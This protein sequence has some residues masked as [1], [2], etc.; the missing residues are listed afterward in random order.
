MRF[1]A[2]ACLSMV[3]LGP[4]AASL[5]GQLSPRARS[6]EPLV[7]ETST[8]AD[9]LFFAMDPR[10]AYTRLAARIEVAP[11]DYE[12]RWRASR[13]ALVLGV[14]ADDRGVKGD[15]L[16]IAEHQAS[17]A[18]RVR[19]G[20]VEAMAWL[21][22]AKGR[23]ATDIVG[24][25]DQVRLGQEVWELTKRVLA[26]DPAHP[27]GNDVLGK[28]HQE[29]SKLSGFERFV[30][31]TFMGGGDPLRHSSWENSELY[32]QR[33]IQA[34]P[35]VVLFF[36][37]LGDTYRMQGKSQQ[38]RRAYERGL[39]VPDLYPPDP[40]FKDQIRRGLAELRGS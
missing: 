34:D 17:E 11:D 38:A 26:G 28:L 24:V 23:L 7:V 6:V 33:A 14:M 2:P 1:L 12:V 8:A 22:A 18:L 31:R 37:D 10:A 40:K 19:P 15:W 35:T 39:R 36:L 9:S 20:D 30:A 29:V 16:R 32:L 27:L 5:S 3:L 21:A 25:R 13:A 4:P